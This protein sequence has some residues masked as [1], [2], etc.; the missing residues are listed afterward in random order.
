MEELRQKTIDEYTNDLCDHYDAA[1][2][3]KSIRRS[4]NNKLWLILRSIAAGL[5]KIIDAIF[6]LRNRFDPRYCTDTDLQT[7][8]RLMGVEQMGGSAS[9]IEI[10]AINTSNENSYTLAS[11][12]YEFTSAAGIL[13]SFEIQED[14]TLAAQQDTLFHAISNI[15]GPY[16]VSAIS[17]ANVVRKDKAAI[18]AAIVFNIADNEALLG[19]NQESLYDVRQRILNYDLPAFMAQELRDVLR[20]EPNIFDADVIVNYNNIPGVV[21]DITLQPYEAMV[22]ISGIVSE[23]T[24][25]ILASY[26][27]F[28]TKMFDP[29]DKIEFFHDTLLGGKHTF[30]YRP[31][32]ILEYDLMIT[33]QFN[34]NATDEVRVE[35]ALIE[36]CRGLRFTNTRKKY[37]TPH[38]IVEMVR[39]VMPIGSAAL[40]ATFIVDGVTE[41]FILP[42]RTRIPRMV[43]LTFNPIEIDA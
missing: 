43:N 7:T 33:Y 37:I 3:P 2:A 31:F 32:D 1:I 28:N 25:E 22:I 30:Y 26:G 4:N 38:E 13:F 23:R 40:N 19:H 34:T 12:I 42:G 21:D 24:G 16:S 17:D 35:N 20:N 14:L 39:E 27:F 6:V 11:G 18:P 9:L 5:S 15:I 41:N 36:A 8:M 10:T 29:D